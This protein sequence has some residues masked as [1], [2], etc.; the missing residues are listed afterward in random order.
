[1]LVNKVGGQ[2]A[3]LVSRELVL[4]LHREATGTLQVHA[5]G[6]HGLTTMTNKLFVGGHG[7]STRSAA[8]AAEGSK[9]RM[10]S[11]ATFSPC[12][13]PSQPCPRKVWRQKPAFCD[14]CSGHT[15]LHVFAEPLPNIIHASILQ[16]LQCPENWSTAGASN[17]S[18]TG[19]GERL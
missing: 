2:D 17:Q 16:G 5:K 3:L 6:S 14:T 15:K 12:C 11:I 18:N 8:M 9:P 1:M 10:P 7:I 13:D 19:D 4:S